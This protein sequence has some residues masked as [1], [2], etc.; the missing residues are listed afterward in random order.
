MR[1]GLGAVRDSVC[2]PL[3]TKAA[4]GP[5]GARE[6]AALSAVERAFYGLRQVSRGEWLGDEWKRAVFD[7]AAQGFVVIVAGHDQDAGLG[8]ERLDTVDHCGA[9]AIG[10]HDVSEQQVDAVRLSG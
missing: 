6:F 10:E 3:L 2:C 4:P 9:S 5:R 7:A 1:R 8:T